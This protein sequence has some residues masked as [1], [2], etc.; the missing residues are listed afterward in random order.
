MSKRIPKLHAVTRLEA[1][2]LQALLRALKHLLDHTNR[3]H[4]PLFSGRTLLSLETQARSLLRPLSAL[5]I[6]VLRKVGAAGRRGHPTHFFFGIPEWSAVQWLRTNRL[7]EDRARMERGHYVGR[8]YH[9]TARG[10]AVYR[11]LCKLDRKREAEKEKA[12]LAAQEP[13]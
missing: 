8:F 9:L 4:L 5:R 1:Q 6:A 12:K 3:A 10:R 2:Q 7:L 11:D 13:W